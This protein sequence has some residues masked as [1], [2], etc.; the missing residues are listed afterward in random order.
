MKK[1][2]KKRSKSFSF[3]CPAGLMNLY[4]KH[5]TWPFFRLLMSFIAFNSMKIIARE[6]KEAFGEVIKV[7]SFSSSLNPVEGKK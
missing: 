5:Y 7:V 4:T 1:E 2:K 3:C 6:E